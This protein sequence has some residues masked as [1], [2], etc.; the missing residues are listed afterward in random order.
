MYERLDWRK[1][2]KKVIEFCLTRSIYFT[3]KMQFE[4]SLLNQAFKKKLINF[5]I[6]GFIGVMIVVHNTGV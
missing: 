6:C 3:S 5:D 4:N 2:A 1:S